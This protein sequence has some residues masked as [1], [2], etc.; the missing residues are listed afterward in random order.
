MRNFEKISF[1]RFKKDVADDIEL[2]NAYNLPKRKTKFAAAYDFHA[3]GD[4]M[5][6]PGETMKIPTGVKVAM[7]NDEVLLLI[8][9]SSMGFK[10]NV[11]LCNQ[12]G[13]IDADYYNNKDNEGH[14]WI[15]IQNEGNEDYHIKKGDGMCQ[16]MFIKYL[17]VDDEENDFSERKSNY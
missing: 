11:R 2:Y 17:T 12:V 9:R 8:S 6:K 1:D 7:E 10:Y 16:G 15:R 3:M 13:V 14:M 4:Y 5:L